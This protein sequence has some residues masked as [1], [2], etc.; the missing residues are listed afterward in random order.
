MTIDAKLGTGRRTRYSRRRIVGLP[1]QWANV[2][3]NLHDL[4]ACQQAVSER[5]YLCS[6]GIFVLRVDANPQRLNDR[7]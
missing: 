3:G 5:Q 7:L 6:T 2:V 1:R 4:V